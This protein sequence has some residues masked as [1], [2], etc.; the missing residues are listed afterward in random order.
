MKLLTIIGARPQIIK[1][2]AV[3]RAL[4]GHSAD[5]INEYILHTGQ[6]YD[7]NMSAQFF[8]ELGIPRPTYNLAVGSCSHGIQ[9]AKMIG[10]IEEVLTHN[11]FDGVIVYGDTNSTLAGALA[12]AKLQ[13]PVFHVEAGLRSF[14]M[15]MP[16]EQNRIVTDQLS[17]LCFAPT[18]TAVDNLRHEGFFDSPTQF[19]GQ[20]RRKVV[21]CGDVMLDNTLHYADLAEKKCNIL[22]RLGQEPHSYVLATIHRNYNTD[23]PARLKHLMQALAE[24]AR[25]RH[26]TVLL[27]LHPRTAHLLEAAGAIPDAAQIRTLPPVSYLE[28][29]QLERNA[30]V[31][32]TDSGGV[33]KEAFFLERPC[34]IL[35]TET[36]WTEI[37]ENGAGMLADADTAAILSAFDTLSDRSIHFPPLFGDGHAAEHIVSEIIEYLK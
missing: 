6:H 20:R 35:R 11:S 26:I 7:E 4:S 16:E 9:T 34:I 14:N 12:A 37:I 24:V 30:Q 15:T 23:D 29:L 18:R 8:E 25:Q 1:A 21:L 31:V 19:F 10:G 22:Q 2:A 3:S 17:N 5:G 28:M 32:M 13:I 33:Q 36:E 27:P